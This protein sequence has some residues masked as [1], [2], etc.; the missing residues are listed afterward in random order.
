MSIFC[1]YK[2]F[3]FYRAKFLQFSTGPVIN[4]VLTV[5]VGALLI[6]QYAMG[7]SGLAYAYAIGSLVSSLGFMLWCYCKSSV[8]SDSQFP[9]FQLFQW[10]G[11]QGVQSAQDIQGCRYWMERL[12]AVCSIEAMKKIFKQGLPIAGY[13]AAEL[14]SLV[15]L[16]LLVGALGDRFLKMTQPFLQYASVLANLT[17][18]F[19]QGSGILVSKLYQLDNLEAQSKA[20]QV[21]RLSIQLGLVL[22]VIL[23]ALSFG[24]PDFLNSVFLSSKDA[25]LLKEARWFLIIGALSLIFDSVRNTASG[26]GRGLAKLMGPVINYSFMIQNLLGIF[27]VNIPLSFALSFGSSLGEFGSVTA[28][29]AAIAL[30]SVLIFDT[31][32]KTKEQPFKNLSLTQLVFPSCFKA[33]KISKESE[34][35]LSH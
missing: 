13:A 19:G 24:V 7:F 26:A 30:S 31:W 1:L 25:V 22:P 18:A 27:I 14:G 35:L 3:C 28:R 32:R 34:S 11:V 4:R 5:G 6:Y 9:A 23:I 17:F 20:K 12:R 33:G 10:S 8:K 2:F 16:S 21:G 15:F 29:T